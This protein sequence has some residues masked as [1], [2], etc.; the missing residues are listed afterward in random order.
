VGIIAS[1]TRPFCDDCDRTRLT[2]AAIAELGIE[3]GTSLF[4]VIKATA[5]T[6][7]AR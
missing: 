4:A 1:I 2:A 6:L 3:V 5:I 7:E